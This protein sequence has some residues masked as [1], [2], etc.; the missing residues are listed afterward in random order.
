MPVTVGTFNLN[1]LFSRFNFQAEITD[2]SDGNGL[3]ASYTF[4]DPTKVRLRRYRGRLVEGK[5]A[6][7]RGHVARRLLGTHEEILPIVALPQVDV[8]AVQEVEDIDTLRFFAANDLGGAYPHV[9]LIEGND[10]RLIDLAV[11]SRLPLG[12]VTSWQHATHPEAPGERVFGRD[13]LEV[14]VLSA[15]RSRRLFTLFNNHLKSHFV[16]F[17]EDQD[18]GAEAANRRRRQQAETIADI[19]AARTRPDSRYVV[20][21]DMNDPPTSEWLQAFTAST[22]LRLVDGLAAPVETRPAK[23]DTPPPGTAAWTHRF[24]ESGQPTEYELFDH[25]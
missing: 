3:E 17:D 7:G 4:S 11:L 16:P 24:K 12:A 20:L 9:T 13:L 1:N 5:D 8:W 21:G 23:A 2:N 15:D 6:A 18:A 10:P 22:T 19:V 25:I 14:E